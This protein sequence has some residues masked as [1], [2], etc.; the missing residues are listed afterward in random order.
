MSRFDSVGLAK[1]TALGTKNTVMTYFVP[2][3]SADPG[4]NRETL[5]IEETLGNKFPTDIEYGS[6]FYEVSFS[7]AVRVASLPRVLSGFLGAP[8][9]TT[10]G[11]GTSSRNHAFNPA[12]GGGAALVPHSI[13]VNRTDP[14][15]G[16]TDLFWDALGNS[17]TMSVDANGFLSFDAAYVAKEL[18]DTQPEPTVTADLTR[19]FPFHEAKCYLSVDGGAEAEVKVSSFSLTYNNNIATDQVVLGSTSLYSTPEGNVDADYSFTTKE[20]LS[21][22]YRRALQATPANVKVRLEALGP[23]IEGTIKYKVEVIIYRSQTIDA[24]AGISAGDFL[25]DI[26]VSGRAAYDSATSKFVEVNVVNIV[27][28]Y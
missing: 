7:G 22:H 15:P 21:T 18:D 2:V 23:I 4:I 6:R 27:P 16:I 3:D 13:L 14:S 20:A 9:T 26:D 25:R 11:G 24:P 28:S 19:R 8:T 12:A 1:Q 5:E 17:F 10:P